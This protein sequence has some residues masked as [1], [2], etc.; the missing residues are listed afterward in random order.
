[1]KPDAA[2]HENRYAID[3]EARDQLADLLER[4][5]RQD[6]TVGGFEDAIFAGRFYASPDRAVV[7]I[8][9]AADDITTEH[10][11]RDDVLASPRLADVTVTN[12]KRCV[13]FLRSDR[14]YE[15][16]PRQSRY[17]RV[18]MILMLWSVVGMAAIPLAT[19]FAF[20]RAVD[21]LVLGLFNAAGSL[22][23]VYLLHRDS[24]IEYSR[25]FRRLEFEQAAWPYCRRSDVPA[26]PAAGSDLSTGA[27]LDSQ[28]VE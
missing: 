17:Q 9:A 11:S 7:E 6:L 8:A 22:F 5:L 25:L 26:Q 23:A 4:L 3:R 21:G 2:S 28:A 10:D 19:H 24:E 20:D 27:F 14:E 1:M 12:S 16:P 15:W 13:Q 18:C